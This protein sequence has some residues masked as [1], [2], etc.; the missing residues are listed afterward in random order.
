MRG[1]PN[2]VWLTSPAGYRRDTTPE[3]QR[4]AAASAGQWYGNC[5]AH[6]N[7]TRISTA[8]IITGTYP[9]HHGVRKNRTIPDELD[10]VPEILS[11]QG[12]HTV[13]ISRNANSSMGFNRGFDEFEWISSDSFLESVDYRTA[14]KY[15]LNIRRHSAGFDT[16]TAKHS[17]PFILN[18]MAKRRIR[19]YAGSK[20]PFF[21]Y[22]HYNEPHRPYFPPLP[23]LNEY[24]DEIAMSTEEAVELAMEMHYNASET[25]AEGVPYSDEEWEALLALYDA[26][27]AY[28]DEC[29][30]RLFDYL[31]SA[32]V[33]ETIFVITADHGEMFGELGMLAHKLVL[34]DG[35]INV[36]LVVHGLNEY[37]TNEDALLQH[38]DVMETLVSMA[39]GDTGQFQGI[40][41]RTDTRES[42]ISQDWEQDE[43]LDHLLELN[44]E[45]DTDPYHRP[46]LTC[47]RDHT[48]KYQESDDG[49]ELFELPDEETDVSEEYPEQAE[50]MG[51]EFQ[52]WFEADGQPVSTDV[53]EGEFS[54]AMKDQLSDL[55][56][57][58]D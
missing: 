17:T 13:G 7:T 33:G 34:H 20:E 1:A 55:G 53:T 43:F 10:T 26:E 39:G 5:F 12:Y 18:D 38:A 40:D 6:S 24:T 52:E 47:L 31:Q 46:L 21:M 50:E 56:Y 54:D 48:F 35:L 2:V 45:F 32:N 11:E 8:S 14:L 25:I 42:V 44:P 57:L 16:D 19:S 22:L 29:V 23:Y 58:V 15:A 28:T 30:G 51:A 27:I 3:M 37:P 9:S 4:I 41:P 36:P 49:S